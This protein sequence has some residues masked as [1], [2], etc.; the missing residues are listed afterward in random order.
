MSQPNH[1]TKH[2]EFRD[3]VRE[4]FRPLVIRTL[5]VGESPPL[6]DDFFYCG[7]TGMTT[8]MR[9]SFGEAFDRTFLSDGDFVAF[10]RSLGCYIDD[11]CLEP[12]NKTSSSERRAK[13]A[14]SIGG[15]A[16]RLSSY[17]P[18]RV[19]TIL[20]RIEKPVHVA[21]KK[22]GLTIPV[23]ILPFPGN[24]WQNDFLTQL[25]PILRSAYIG[26]S[27]AACGTVTASSR[28][29]SVSDRIMKA[30]STASTTECRVDGDKL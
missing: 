7:S 4:S 14:A 6:G 3:D 11:L 28:A 17:R 19:I 23:H 24:H 2:P 30:R 12:I 25:V 29:G 27:P 15:F 16:E 5:F 1:D 9:K 26:A 8:Y 21:V 13:T 20:K 18:E 10:F 22:S